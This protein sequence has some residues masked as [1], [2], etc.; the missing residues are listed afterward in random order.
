LWSEIP[1]WGETH[2]AFVALQSDPRVPAPLRSVATAGVLCIPLRFEGESLGAICADAGGA[3]VDLSEEELAFAT[4]LGGGTA[5]A[6]ANARLYHRVTT[7]SEEKSTFLA[8]IAHE[9]R[10][11][12]HTLLWD[13]DALR[14]QGGGA[15]ST[16]ER[17][18][19]NTLLTLNAAEEL[20]EFSEVE[21]RRLTARA[22]PVALAQVFDE[23]GTTAL[24]LL[25]GR[26][27][28]FHSRIGEGAEVL[29][30]DPFRIRQ[31]LG[32]LLS[33]AAKFTWRGSIELE[34]VRKGES[35]V[36][37]VQDTGAGVEASELEAI[38][39]PFY[40]GRARAAG[41]TRG[42]GLGLAIAQEIATLLRGRIEVESTPGVGS[43]FRVM[44]PAGTVAPVQG[45]PVPERALPDTRVLVIE[46]D[47]VERLR[48]VTALR[49][50]GA[51]VL[52]ARDGFEGLRR[53][54]EHRPDLIVLDLGLPG[55]SGVDVLTRLRRD[56]EL[57]AVPV[58]VATAHADARLEAHCREAGC[59]AYLRKPYAL[60]ELLA[61][62][63]R[64]V[65]E[66]PGRLLATAG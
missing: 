59:V 60:G 23:L 52:E 17:L 31:V 29:V 16:I 2:E 6:M 63:W 36:L 54:H 43:N 33:N 64:V 26:P 9:L 11:P 42:M 38:F 46:D 58:I 20:Q 3:D 37:S 15:E 48:T 13:I 61:A 51:Q 66:Q 41:I 25:A 12:L 57:A 4:V 27:I 28:T 45:H 44:L 55:L 39:T 49:Q 21:T 22:E 65:D 30:T 19:Q 47:A 18:R 53:A 56:G 50:N 35:I 10:N 7:A 24:A 32:N 34:A 1:G 14:G 5:I 8:R 62:T 40:R